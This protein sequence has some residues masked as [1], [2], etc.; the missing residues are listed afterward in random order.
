MTFAARVSALILLAASVLPVCAQPLVDDRQITLTTA[1]S[2]AARRA[3]L[4]NYVWGPAGFPSSRLPTRSANIRSPVDGLANVRRVDELRA[5]MEAGESSIAY[6]FIPTKPNNRVVVLQNGHGCTFNEQPEKPGGPPNSGLRRA[7]SE[8]LAEGFAVLAVF[9]PRSDPQDC[10]Y[11]THAEMFSI[12][13]SSGNPV[14]FFLEPTA[15][16]MNY[17]EQC[18]G[19][20]DFPS[21]REYDMAGLSGGGW[22]IGRAHV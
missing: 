10:R 16:F 7:I 14:K 20:D 2:V 17:L 11:T 12:Q 1:A 9:M 6:H 15:V 19:V 5:A 18:S 13:L 4:I 3:A 8:L 22:K 21:Y